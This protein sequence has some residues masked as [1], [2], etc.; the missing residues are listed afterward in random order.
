MSSYYYLFIYLHTQVGQEVHVC[1][2]RIDEANN[3]LI[4]SEKEAWVSYLNLP[5][6]PVM[7]HRPHTLILCL[8]LF[9]L[10]YLFEVGICCIIV[11]TTYLVAL[12]NVYARNFSTCLPFDKDVSRVLSKVPSS[13]GN[14]FVNCHTLIYEWIHEFLS[15]SLSLFPF[16]QIAYLFRWCHTLEKGRSCKGQSASYFHMV[17]KL[18]LARLTEGNISRP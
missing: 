15:L 3:E 9:L 8:T 18:G 11:L 17:H 1:I 16:K 7:K 12:S 10:L 4:I 2:T 14:T 6:L 5:L 13:F